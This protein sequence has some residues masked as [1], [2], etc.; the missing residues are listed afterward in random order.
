MDTSMNK[1]VKSRKRGA[2]KDTNSKINYFS[3]LATKNSNSR[4]KIALQSELLRNKKDSR[5]MR[6]QEANVPQSKE[7]FHQNTKPKEKAE[8][9]ALENLSYINA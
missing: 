6:E 2:T 7:N 9:T 3:L 5:S 8:I 1:D 4:K